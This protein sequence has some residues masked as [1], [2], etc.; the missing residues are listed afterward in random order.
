MVFDIIKMA[1]FKRKT[2][3]DYRPRDRQAETLRRERDRQRGRQAETL[4]RE[5]DRQRGRQAETLRRERDRQ[6]GRQAET[7]RRERDRQRGRQTESRQRMKR[8]NGRYDK[9]KTKSEEKETNKAETL[10][11]SLVV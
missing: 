1:K 7:L 4:R 2:E 11:F 5:R 8:E 3:R 9:Q 6:R 10:L